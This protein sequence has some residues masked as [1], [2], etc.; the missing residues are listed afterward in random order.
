MK[1]F[2]IDNDRLVPGLYKHSVSGLVTTWDLRIKAPNKGDYLSPAAIHTIEH[3]LA[4]YIR[5]RYGNYKI[6]GVF[7]MG[8]QTGFYIL[9]RGMSRVAIYE[10]VRDYIGDL[11]V[12]VRIPGATAKQCG[13]YQLQDLR[14]AKDEL[15]DFYC[16]TFKFL[17][18]A[19]KYE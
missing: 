12:T 15:W 13:Q 5:G 18:S 17:N 1:S 6:V 2:E 9:T 4:S 7:P 8:C 3:T 10:A 14:A 19:I 16:N 11:Q